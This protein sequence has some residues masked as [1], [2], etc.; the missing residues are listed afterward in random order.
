MRSSTHVAFVCHLVG[1][2][3]Y[4]MK[5]VTLHLLHTYYGPIDNQIFFTTSSLYYYCWQWILSVCV[6]SQSRSLEF[7]SWFGG[8]KEMGLKQIL[9][10]LSFWSNAPPSTRLKSS[11]IW[12][13]TSKSTQWR[14]AQSG[15]IKPIGSL[16]G[17]GFNCWSKQKSLSPFEIRSF[18]Q[19]D[20]LS[21]ITI[22]LMYVNYGINRP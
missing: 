19:S 11:G 1:S 15:Q 9:C 18:S 2:T 16:L 3:N 10:F 4:R 5:Q 22:Y 12:H 13:G 21:L 6:L 14:T 17:W 20:V 8:S 7:L